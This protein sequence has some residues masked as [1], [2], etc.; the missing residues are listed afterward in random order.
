MSSNKWDRHKLLRTVSALLPTGMVKKS[1]CA[2]NR[3]AFPTTRVITR[4]PKHHW[5]GYYDKLQFDPTSRY[6]L[7]MEFDFEYRSPRPGDVIKIGMVDLE[8][9]DHWIELGAS[10]AW[11]WQQGCMLQWLPGST[12]KMLWNDHVAGRFVCHILDTK[13]KVRRPI[14]YAIYAVIPD[15]KSAVTYAL[16]SLMV[17]YRI[18]IGEPRVT[19]LPNRKIVWETHNEGIFC[20]KTEKVAA[21][22]RLAWES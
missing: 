7:G 9:N 14:P 8:D 18:S 16:L 3:D 12:T 22:N 20:L 21:P 15:G 2:Q 6:V 11:C 17:T 1:G 19:F 13:T 5:F 4:E 10:R